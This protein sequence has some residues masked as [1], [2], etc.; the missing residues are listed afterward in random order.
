LVEQDFAGEETH[1]RGD[2]VAERELGHIARHELGGGEAGP[3]SVA[4]HIR[5]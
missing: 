3:G 4:Q 5:R 1:I 2:D